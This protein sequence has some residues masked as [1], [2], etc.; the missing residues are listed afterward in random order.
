MAIDPIKMQPSTICAQSYKKI[1]ELNF[2]QVL[3]NTQNIDAPAPVKE[4]TLNNPSLLRVGAN[5]I[6]SGMKDSE[7]MNKV[8]KLMLSEQ[9]FSTKQL[10]AVQAV[11]SRASVGVSAVGKL[12][13]QACGSVKSVLQQNV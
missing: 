10:L 9:E 8:V 5:A 13:E 7:V 12:A 11:V 4:I 1:P 6:A 2:S 3:K